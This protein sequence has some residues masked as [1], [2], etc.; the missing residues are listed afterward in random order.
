[1]IKLGQLTDSEIIER[2]RKGEVRYQ[3]RL[4]KRF[5]SYAMGVSLRYAINREDALEIV[6]DAFIKIFDKLHS[7]DSQRPFKPWLRQIIINQTIDKKRR[8]LKAE[9]ELPIDEITEPV[10]ENADAISLL[11]YKDILQMLNT[12]PEIQS[13]VFNMYEIDGYAHEEIAQMLDISTSSSRV[14]L[15]RAKEKLR[16]LIEELNTEGYGRAV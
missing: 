13:L 10:W 14:Y 8:L 2:C 7:F 5:Y 12:L 3:E 16:K 6:N 15:S 1:M 4:Y 11:G 9:C